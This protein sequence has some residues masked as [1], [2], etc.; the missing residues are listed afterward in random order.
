MCL[1]YIIYALFAFKH[2]ANFDFFNI[3]MRWIYSH[4]QGATRTARH[5]GLR[6]ILLRIRPVKPRRF[7]PDRGGIAEKGGSATLP[8]TTAG[9]NWTSF[10]S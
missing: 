3:L 2:N 9:S 5:S 4:T 7:Y 1:I 8:A 10:A 6:A